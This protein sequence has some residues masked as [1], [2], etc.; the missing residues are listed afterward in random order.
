MS[1]VA[2]VEKDRSSLARKHASAATS[3][4]FPIRPSGMRS[5]LTSMWGWDRPVRIG[6]SITAGAM[7]LTRMPV[8]TTSLPIAF[9]S[10]I[11]AP[12]DEE[13]AAAIGVAL[14]AGDRR[15]FDDPAVAARLHLRDRGAV[16]EEDA[17]QVDRVHAL[18][19]LVG[20]V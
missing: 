2:P 19:L 9:V 3:S 5:T 10:A 12:F 7:L 14:L 13:Y 4:A 16:R 6:V 11:T 15:D 20:D 17:V 18:P 1:Y 8:P